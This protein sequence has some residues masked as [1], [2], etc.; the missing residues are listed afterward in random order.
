MFIFSLVCSSQVSA[1]WFNR[2]VGSDDSAVFFQFEIECLDPMC[3]SGGK[4]VSSIG[5]F[6]GKDTKKIEQRYD[7]KVKNYTFDYGNGLES[8]VRIFTKDI[9]SIEYKSIEVH[10]IK[11]NSPLTSF[12]SDS[13]AFISKL[14]SECVSSHGDAGFID[15]SINLRYPYELKQKIYDQSEKYD[16]V[17]EATINFDGDSVRGNEVLF[18]DKVCIDGRCQV[19]LDV[20]IGN[21]FFAVSKLNE[22]SKNI[23]AS[24][25][26]QGAGGHPVMVAEIPLNTFINI[27]NFENHRPLE[28]LKGKVIDNLFGEKIHIGNL[29]PAGR[30][31]SFT[32]SILGPSTSI[33]VNFRKGYWYKASIHINISLNVHGGTLSEILTVSVLDMSEIRAPE[34]LPVLPSEL[35][36]SGRTLTYLDDGGQSVSQDGELIDKWTLF[37]SNKIVALVGGRV[38]GGW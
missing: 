9:L 6:A 34:H 20:G 21:E 7:P 11:S 12:F 32:V 37:I 3:T 29:L 19:W 14:N 5:F 8:K 23:C 2:Y 36:K 24:R 28:K 30:G 33:G 26:G 13:N 35:I 17:A 4:I 16:W 31:K 1:E 38:D 25:E 10:L 15:G 27:D 18:S 22:I